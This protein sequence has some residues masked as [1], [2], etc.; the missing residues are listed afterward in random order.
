[1]VALAFCERS[2]IFV[3]KLNNKDIEKVNSL[4]FQKETPNFFKFSLKLSS[5][6]G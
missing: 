1:M 3:V 2:W 4:F 6:H 5:L